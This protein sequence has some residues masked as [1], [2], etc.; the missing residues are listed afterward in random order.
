MSGEPPTAKPVIV[1]FLDTA[2]LT[3]VEARLGNRYHL[4]TYADTVLSDAL[5]AALADAQPALMLVQPTDES[6]TMRISTVKT[7]PATRRI[8][9][10]AI[11]EDEGDCREA[12]LAGADQC[13]TSGD[14]LDTLEARI[15]QTARV[16]SAEQQHAIQEGCDE[17]LPEQARL[18]VEM[19]N[20]GEYYQQHDLFEA[21]WMETE[22][23][24]R[25][26]YRAI[27]QIGIAYYQITR[28]NE[29]S[30][31]KMLL[32]SQQW[33]A[34]L[35]DE[36]QGIDI[37]QLKADVAQVRSALQKR[38]DGHTTAFDVNL[39]KPVVLIPR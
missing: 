12:R 39:L 6:W 33:L 4:I 34:L 24:I 38:P 29:R 7:S 19:F 2:L 23:P 1:A 9:I 36:C 26:L 35:P 18:A 3:A 28:G 8:P 16:V 10:I 17:L 11:S 15:E 31:M 21:L 14:L 30:A 5:V 25:D 13:I 22:A 20:A 27:L 37:G 32:R